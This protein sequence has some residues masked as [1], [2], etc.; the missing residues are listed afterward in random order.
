MDTD[1]LEA[2]LNI[3]QERAPVME[4]YD[5][6]AEWEETKVQH[7]LLFAVEP[8]KRS[9]KA[10]VRRWLGPIRAVDN[11]VA[12]V[13]CLM[14]TANAF[15]YNPIRQFLNWADGIIHVYSNPSG[16]MTLPPPASTTRWRRRWRPMAGR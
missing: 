6:E 8:S 5:P 2:Y 9:K 3:L 11:A 4:D 7:P 15:G 13:L 12:E 16:E 10:T 14:I 1:R